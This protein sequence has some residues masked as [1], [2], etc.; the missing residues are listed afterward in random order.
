RRVGAHRGRCRGGGAA[1]GDHVAA[2]GHGRGFRGPHGRGP[3]SPGDRFQAPR[4]TPPHSWGGGARQGDG[5]GRAI[6][7]A[8]L[9]SAPPRSGEES[10]PHSWGG[11]ARQG[12]GG[13]RTIPSASLCSAPPRS[14]EESPPHS[15]GGGARQGD[16]G[17]RTIPSASLCSAPPR[18]RGGV[19]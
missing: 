17:G 4:M 15:W 2:A 16:G 8:S 6:P 13:G 9:C 18:E 7:S 5:G 1:G 10:P 12:D 19:K 3:G 14:G 11:G